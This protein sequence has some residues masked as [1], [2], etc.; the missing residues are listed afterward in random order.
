MAANKAAKPEPEVGAMPMAVG[1]AADK[2]EGLPAV[3]H[4][5]WE[6]QMVRAQNEVLGGELQPEV[7]LVGIVRAR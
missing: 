5:A 2:E 3:W 7:Q 1:G 6:A 4:K